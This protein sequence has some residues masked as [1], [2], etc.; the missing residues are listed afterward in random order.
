MSNPNKKDSDLTISKST[1]VMRFCMLLM[2]V[3][4]IVIGSL[5]FI[6]SDSGPVSGKSNSSQL[7]SPQ[8]SPF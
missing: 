3:V 5:N 8:D 1:K 4:V 6:M 2:T 7:S